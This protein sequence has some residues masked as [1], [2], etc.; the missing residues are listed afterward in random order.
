MPISVKCPRVWPSRCATWAMLH[1]SSACTDAAQIQEYVL[2]QHLVQLFAPR[3][4][5]PTKIVG[6]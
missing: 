1:E 2:D 5:Q 6:F 4:T 3:T